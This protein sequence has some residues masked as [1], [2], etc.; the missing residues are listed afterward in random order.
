MKVKIGSAAAQEFTNVNTE[1]G[2]YARIDL[3]NTYTLSEDAF[4]YTVPGA[5]ETIEITFTV[6][7]W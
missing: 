3:I 5:N 7:G 2:D 6:S 1:D 4:G